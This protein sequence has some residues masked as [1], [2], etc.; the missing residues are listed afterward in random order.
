MYYATYASNLRAQAK[1][2]WDLLKKNNDL[3]LVI[4]V[5]IELNLKFQ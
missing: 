5:K 1:Q 2:C 4:T 3:T